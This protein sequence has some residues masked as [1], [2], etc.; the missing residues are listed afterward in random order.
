M[1]EKT[2]DNSHPIHPP[3]PAQRHGARR[4]TPGASGIKMLPS[5]HPSKRG[6]IKGCLPSKD[7]NAIRKQL[8]G[9][10]R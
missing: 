5:P 7:K 1:E 4:N 2:R 9:L 8:A 3:C 10:P 6:E